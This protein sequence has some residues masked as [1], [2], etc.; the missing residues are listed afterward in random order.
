[1]PPSLALELAPD[2]GHFVRGEVT[3]EAVAD[4]ALDEREGQ[5]D[6]FPPFI[7]DVHEHAPG[8]LGVRRAS[9][10]PPLLKPLDDVVDGGRTRR[11]AYSTICQG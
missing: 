6:R 8:V 5:G 11:P 2:G 1:M 7:G 3:R 10:E 9:D 4:F